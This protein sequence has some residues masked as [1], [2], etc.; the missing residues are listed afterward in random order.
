MKT[1]AEQSIIKGLQK[2]TDEYFTLLK[3]RSA[4]EKKLNVLEEKMKSLRTAYKVLT[5]E[6]PS[7]KEP[8]MIDLFFGANTTLG[9]S[10]EVLL[11]EHRI[12]E[13]NQAI[14]L[15]RKTKVKLSLKN[16]RNV[17]ANL[18]KNDKKKRFTRL[19]DG[20]IILREY[21]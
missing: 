2:F 1:Q 18:V 16:A 12:L 15:L 7:I 19:E 3:K 10:L 4:L 11:I 14:E 21:K 9:D 8:P 13:I 20:R 5:G 17:L 6:E